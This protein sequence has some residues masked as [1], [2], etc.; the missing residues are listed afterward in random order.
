[1]GISLKSLGSGDDS[2]FL[3][4]RTGNG[5]VELAPKAVQA[6]LINP[7]A[8]AFVEVTVQSDRNIYC[9]YPKRSSR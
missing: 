5:T 7:R 1:M 3:D 2:G 8:K 4:D 6:D 9:L